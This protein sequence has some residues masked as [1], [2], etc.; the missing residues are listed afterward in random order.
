MSPAV[1]HPL[2]TAFEFL[3]MAIGA[4]AVL[5]Q[6]WVSVPLFMDKGMSASGAFFNVLSFFTILSNIAVVI[7]YTASLLKARGRIGVLFQTPGAQSAMAIYIFVVACV[8][9][10][11][12]KDIW[13]PQGIFKILDVTLHYITPALYLIYWLL[14]VTKGKT[15]Y[16]DCGFWLLPGLLYVIYALA[17]GALTGLY[18]YPF[19]D[20]ANAGYPAVML[21]TGLLLVFFLVLGFVLVALDHMLARA[22]P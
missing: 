19:L 5:T 21:N 3:G 9:I 10:A 20:A 7:F 16:R 22:K 4:I 13:E 17:R 2:R 6:F 8:Y 14:C 1:S 18:P 15:N 11:V 12:L